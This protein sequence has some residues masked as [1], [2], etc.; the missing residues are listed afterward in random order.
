MIKN[1]IKKKYFLSDGLMAIIIVSVIL[2]ID[3]IIKMTVKTHMYLGESIRVT[4]WFFID[5]VENNG[6][7]YGM[8]FFNKLVLSVFRIV[9]VSAIAY[10]IYKVLKQKHHTGY[11][12]CLSMVFAGATGN[13]IDCLIYGLIF[14]SSSFFKISQFVPWGDGYASFLHGKVVDMFYFPLIVTTWPHWIPFYGGREFVF[15]SPVFNFADACIS[16]GV[17]LLLLFY[18]RDLESVGTIFSLRRKNKSSSRKI[19]QKDTES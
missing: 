18:R 13:I 3:Q 5:F 7:A 14:D 9:A 4:D 12:V 15:F 19:S 6:M 8:T 16:V 10:Y 1:T 11:I 2:I 17:V